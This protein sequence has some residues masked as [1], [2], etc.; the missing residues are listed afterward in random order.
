MIIPLSK[1]KSLVE[2]SNQILSN[3]FSSGS[4]VFV[5]GVYL[6]FNNQSSFFHCRDF[7]ISCAIVVGIRFT[8]INLSK[9]FFVLSAKIIVL[10]YELVFFLK[11]IKN[12]VQSVLL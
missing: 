9:Q 2:Q 11:N 10:P 1:Y 5:K 3:L 4:D 12:T 8:V 7:S 6:F